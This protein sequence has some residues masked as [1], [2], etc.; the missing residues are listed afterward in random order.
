MLKRLAG[1]NNDTKKKNNNVP[2]GKGTNKCLNSSIMDFLQTHRGQS[3][4]RE[5]TQ[6]KRGRAAVLKKEEG[7]F[8]LGGV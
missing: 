4:G 2:G 3:K 7:R 5:K 6:R 1:Y 8:Y